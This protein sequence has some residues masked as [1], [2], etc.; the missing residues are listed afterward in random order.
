LVLAFVFIDP[1]AP[2]AMYKPTLIVVKAV[3]DVRFG[4][5][6]PRFER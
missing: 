3:A 6:W 5:T 1:F 2:P 4:Q